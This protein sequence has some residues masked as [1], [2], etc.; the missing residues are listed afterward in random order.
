MDL[1]PR[2]IFNLRD[3]VTDSEINRV[4]EGAVDMF[5]ACYGVSQAGDAASDRP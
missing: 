5:L 3:S 4:A 1:F 2:M